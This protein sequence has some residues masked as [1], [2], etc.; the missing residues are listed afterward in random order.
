MISLS[1]SRKRNVRAPV[2]QVRVHF[3][4]LKTVLKDVDKIYPGLVSDPRKIW[5]WDETTI[6]YESG[7]KTRFHAS[8]SHN[9]GVA[10][11]SVR[12]SG[13]HVTAGITIAACGKIS[14]LF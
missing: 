6:L 3:L 11:R 10:R 12:D 14:P 4:T 1:S 9:L 13:K 2:T 7:K 8:A 5:N